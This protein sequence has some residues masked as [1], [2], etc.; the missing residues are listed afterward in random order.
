VLEA[1]V[2][3]APQRIPVT[4]ADAAQP[5]EVLNVFDHVGCIDTE[6]S[7]FVKLGEADGRPDLIGTYKMFAEL[8][9]NTVSG[10]GFIDVT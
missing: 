6:R 10:I 8:V 9:D 7:R 3:P 2:S 1:V 4:V 5:F